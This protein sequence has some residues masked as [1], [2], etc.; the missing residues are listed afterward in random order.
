[1]DLLEVPMT[2]TPKQPLISVKID[3]DVYRL[4]RTVAAWRG[5]NISDYLTGI[6]RPIAERDVARIN[7]AAKKP[8]KKPS[9]KPTENREDG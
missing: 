8:A 3:A 2:D 1:L 7:K 6:V 5:E 4:I 9:K